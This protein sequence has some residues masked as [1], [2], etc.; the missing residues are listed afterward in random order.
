MSTKIKCLL[1]DDELPGLTYLKR[2]CEQ[3][4]DLE[5]VKAFDD[6]Q[7]LLDQYKS[8]RFDLCILDIE[9]PNYNG[10]EV[11]KMLKDIPVIFTTAY[12]EY[13]ADAFDIHALDYI[14]KPIDQSR[15]ES[16]IRKV[17]LYLEKQKHNQDSFQVNTN[18]GKS[19]IRFSDIIYI[20]SSEIDKR[21]KIIHLKNQPALTIK[22]MNY[23]Q[24]LDLLSGKGFSRINKKDIIALSGVKHFTSTSVSIHNGNEEHPSL[25]Q[26]AV[27][28]VYKTQ[29]QKQLTENQDR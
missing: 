21:D 25:I 13:A 28:D 14:R 15:L 6:P 12:K 7:K 8:L 29:F 19:V 17:A 16:A 2:L 24:I 23:E 26:I 5:V 1:L 9:M 27:S 3:I 4:P 11:A 20:T 22:N 18:K 10:L